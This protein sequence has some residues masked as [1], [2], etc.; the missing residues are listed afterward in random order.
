[1]LSVAGPF[2]WNNA[3]YKGS[4][5]T[6]VWKV[7]LT[8]TVP[9]V[10]NWMTAKQPIRDCSEIE[11]MLNGIEK[12]SKLKSCLSNRMELTHTV[13]PQLSGISGKISETTGCVNL[14]PCLSHCNR[15]TM[16]CRILYTVE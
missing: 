16:S 4:F 2:F 12:E 10:I 8:H 11:S 15:C 3:Q 6:M 7:F 1:M 9:S 14:H 5:V 13:E